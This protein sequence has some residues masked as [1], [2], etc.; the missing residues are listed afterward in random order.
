MKSRYMLLAGIAVTTCLAGCSDN[1][2]DNGMAKNPVKTGDEILFGS[3]LSND[4]NTK[5]VYGNR[6]K[7]GVAV[8]WVDGDEI[9][10]FCKETSQPANHLVNYKITPDANTPNKASKVMKVNPKAA[11][12]Q[13]GSDDLHHF[14]AFYPA[15]AVHGADS[16]DQQ[17]TIS[18]SIPVNQQPAGWRTGPIESQD[19]TVNGKTTTFALPNMD[20]AY[21]YAYNA[22]DRNTVESGSGTI[23]L[24]FHNLV[25]VLDI[26]IP[27]PEDGS[28]IVVTDVTVRAVGGTNTILTGD[29]NCYIRGAGETGTPTCEPTGDMGEVRNVINIPCYNQEK[30]EYITLGDDEKFLNV[31][32]YIIPDDEN[33]IDK[34]TLQIAVNTLN[35]GEKK[36]TLKYA[37]IVPHK[38]NRVLLPPID[39][40]GDTYWM[41]ALDPDIYV[42][43]LSIPGSKFSVLTSANGA[44]RVYQTATID[45]QLKD[46]VRAFIFQT[47]TKGS[48]SEG[49][50]SYWWPYDDYPGR[51][52]Q[53]TY[54]GFSVVCEGKD[55]PVMTLSDAISDIALYLAD[56][57]RQ[58]KYNEFAFVMLT[59][60]TGDYDL[61]A[62]TVG[63]G[64]DY[65]RQPDDPEQFWIEKLRDEV[66]AIKSDPTNRIYTDEITP[67]TTIDDVKGKIILKANYNSQNMIS[68]YGTTT[69]P[70]M[71]TYWGNAT[72][73]VKGDWTYQ[74]TNG[75]M[76][77]DWGVPVWYESNTN[78]ILRWYYQE[79]TS[80]GTNQEA[81]KQQKEDGIKHLFQ[82]SIDL[83][84]ND[85][86]HKTWFMNDLG[87][88][89]SDSGDIGTREN[90][91]VA[92]TEDMN[93]LAVEKLQ[94][95]TENAGL[96]LIFMNFA[97][98]QA[99]SGAKY[100]SDYLIQTTI[101]N[102]RKFQLRKK[103][104]GTSTTSYNAA[105]K[106]G[107]NAIGWDE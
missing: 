8:N 106:S 70:I 12:L 45:Q 3:S 26:T 18:A 87:G 104:D 72:G 93:N 33:V 28:S 40:D 19:Q 57:E 2:L 92:L 82:E 43:E 56:C 88:Y 20:Y 13:W 17:G 99:N 101:M 22:V 35:G 96:G 79:V 39:S 74:D 24:Q 60:T 62:G 27:A 46:G 67:N 55:K 83:Y 48:N 42:S 77:M 75:G 53:F 71:F 9:A 1:N 50:G 105:Y 68:S 16:D 29:F 85:N 65:T 73:P 47:A 107:G 30:D 37:S 44:S 6:D 10:I 61:G 90:G 36:R 80:V 54:S 21:M 76:P 63:L 66:N 38:V 98:K 84:K 34:R 81:T 52:N 31:K 103:S 97:D 94:Q 86:S 41:S 89:Y 11:G 102:N 32:A 7:E 49:P 91:I 5:T 64:Y 69:A 51:N 15:S 14:Y 25:T 100:K 23:W 78:P 95:R 4:V 58:K 59:Y